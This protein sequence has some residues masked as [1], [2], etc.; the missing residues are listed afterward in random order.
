MSN[1]L[2]QLVNNLNDSDFLNWARFVTRGDMSLNDYVELRDK[3]KKRC[4]SL[5]Y[6][7]TL[8]CC[9][10]NTIIPIQHKKKEKDK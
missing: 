9:N 1:D 4:H 8:G 5:G 6:T 10:Q 7:F 2:D 3:I